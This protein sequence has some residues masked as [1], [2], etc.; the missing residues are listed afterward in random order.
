MFDYHRNDFGEHAD[1]RPPRSW[2]DLQRT[3]EVIAAVERRLGITAFQRD[4]WEALAE[5]ARDCAEAAQTARAMM[6]ESPAEALTRFDGAEL[7]VQVMSA[8]LRRLRP[9]FEALYETLDGAQ[10]RRLYEILA[11]GPLRPYPTD[12]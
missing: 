4:A 10:R 5:T 12:A 7:M 6:R 11:R 1:R 3:E 8:A 2:P 9:K